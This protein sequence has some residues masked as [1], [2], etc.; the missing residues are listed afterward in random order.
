MFNNPYGFPPFIPYSSPQGDVDP[1][2]QMEKTLEFAKRIRDEEKRE[3]EGKKKPDDKKQ[4]IFDKMEMFMM[5][6]A[7][8]SLVQTVLVWMLIRGR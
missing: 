3:Q 2:K 5:L 6:M 1:I 8:S 7:A 4:V